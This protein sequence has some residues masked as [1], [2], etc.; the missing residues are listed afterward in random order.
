[1]GIVAGLD[2]SSAF[3][4]IVVC[5]TDTGEVLRQ[6]YAAHPIEAKAS[7]VD[8]QTW[9]LSLGEA[10]SNGLL[11]GVEGIGVSAQQHGLLP[12]D[13]QGNLVRPALLGND[14]RAQVA[15]ADLV[16]GLGGRQAWA[17]AVG[18]VP[19]AAQPV[20][21]LRW[22]AKNEPENAQRVA[23]VMQPHDW[24][25]WQLLGRPPVVPRTAVPRPAPVTGRRAPAP[26]VPTSWSSRSA[27][28]RRCPRCWARPTPPGRRPRAC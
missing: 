23:A 26:T 28:R 8:P 19:Q 15:A 17:E 4:H 7:E 27:T 10:A 2:S 14:R 6:G 20:S 5:D 13:R 18:S 21:K 16:D 25:V 9:L 12:L 22:L 1:M 11:E 3:T 24:L